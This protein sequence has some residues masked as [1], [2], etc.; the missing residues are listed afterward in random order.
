MS[1]LYDV[2]TMYLI[3]TS[4]W[5]TAVAFVKVAP[6]EADRTQATIVRNRLI[7]F[8]II[9]EGSFLFLD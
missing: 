4:V 8:W 9:K 3:G 6:V 5:V 1:P 7:G 2:K